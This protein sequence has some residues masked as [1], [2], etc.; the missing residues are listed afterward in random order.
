MRRRV[1]RQA[2]ADGF[3]LEV[4][5]L[6][7]NRGQRFYNRISGPSVRRRS[8]AMR[9]WKVISDLMDEFRVVPGSSEEGA[10]GVRSSGM[11][12]ATDSR[13]GDVPAAEAAASGRI[14]GLDA[15]VRRRMRE[16]TGSSAEECFC[17]TRCGVASTLFAA[18]RALIRS[19]SSNAPVP[20]PSSE[21]CPVADSFALSWSRNP[22]K[23]DRYVSWVKGLPGRVC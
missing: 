22:V 15:S 13:G 4:H 10:E 21:P 14:V 5:A 20:S 12:W 2:P 6:A 9:S 19:A 1:R 17:R 7:G 16:V 3:F 23:S 11:A 8:I 18:F